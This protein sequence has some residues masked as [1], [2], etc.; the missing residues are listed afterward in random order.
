M[1]LSIL[2]DRPNDYTARPFLISGTCKRETVTQHHNLVR[3]ALTAITA[4]SSPV[5]RNIRAYVISSDGDSRRRQVLIEMTMS[6]ELSPSSPTSSKFDREKFRNSL[7]PFV[8]GEDEVTNDPDWKH[9]FKRLR[10]TLLRNAGV[11]LDNTSLSADIIK[12]HLIE[13]EQMTAAAADRLLAPNDRQDVVLMIQLLNSISRLPPSDGTLSPSSQ[14]SRRILNLLGTLYRY[15]LESYLDVTLSLD[16]QLTRLSAASHLALALYYQDKGRFIPVQLYFDLQCMIRTVYFCVAKAQVDNPDGEFFIILL[17]TD[18]LEKVFGKV[19]TMVGSDTNVDMLQLGNRVDGA[20]QCVKVLEL[21]P[22]WGGQARRLNLKS[23]KEMEEKITAELDHLSPRS[24]KGDVHHRDI[25]LFTCWSEGERMAAET[26]RKAGLDVPFEYMKETGGFDIL[27]PLGGGKIVLKS[28]PLSDEEQE[29]EEEETARDVEV[30]TD[31]SLVDS[32]G[33][34]GGG[35]RLPD[36]DDLADVDAAVDIETGLPKYQPRVIIDA[37]NPKGLHKASVLRHYSNPLVTPISKDRLLRVRDTQQFDEPE[38]SPS[39]RAALSSSED[40]FLAV[41][42]PALTLVRCGNLIFVAIVSILHIQHD[43]TSVRTLPASLVNQPNVRVHARIMS[44]IC[45]DPSHQPSRSDWQWNGRFE[46]G[47]DL[48]DIDGTLLLLI[49]PDTE[50]GVY[51]SSN[52]NDTYSFKSPELRAMGLLL[53]S[54]TK[55]VRHRIVNIKSTDSF[56]Y[57]LP[58]GTFLF[59]FRISCHTHVVYFF[60]RLRLFYLRERR[61]RSPLSAPRHLLSLR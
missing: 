3:T 38:M 15:L 21:H 26:L 17:G 7:F 19:R 36:L 61:L 11:T 54:R 2:T 42:D 1:A 8:C 45:T 20:V 43:H 35:L 30:G 32:E 4:P 31:G 6:Q 33:Q 23:L 28:G 50:R 58:D 25:V 18:G 13:A 53:F 44:L 14:A 48:R 24:W 37:S 60:A 39:L 51:P 29:E 5:P 22:E 10:N 47:K 9:G 55:D 40:K 16:D 52:G 56:P 57:R 41:E 59:P 34:E 46:S 49:D 27:C 12:M